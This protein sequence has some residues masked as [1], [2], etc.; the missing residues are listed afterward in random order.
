[1]GGIGLMIFPNLKFAGVEDYGITVP[2]LISVLIMILISIERKKLRFKAIE[3]IHPT[4]FTSHSFRT[5]AFMGRIN[6]CPTCLLLRAGTGRG[7]TRQNRV[8]PG[9]G[10]SQPRPPAGPARGSE[11]TRI[12]ARVLHPPGMDPRMSADERR[13]AVLLSL[14]FFPND[15]RNT[16][17]RERSLE[18]LIFAHLR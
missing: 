8:C 6:H 18:P 17:K 14:Y 2:I 12:P 7:E 13:L 16:R 1:M 9:F 11:D 3:T 5:R 10:D 15:T 4:H